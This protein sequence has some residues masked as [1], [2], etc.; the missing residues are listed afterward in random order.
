MV[1]QMR[2][3]PGVA[4]V[5]SASN[6]PA[7]GSLLSIHLA[8]WSSSD[9]RDS[10]DARDA[11]DSRS[12][13]GV[14]PTR[15]NVVDTAFFGAIAVSAL[16][17][18]LFTSADERSRNR[19]VVLSRSL[20]DKLLAGQDPVGRLVTVGDAST[21]AARVVGIVPDIAYALETEDKPIGEAYVLATQ[22]SATLGRRV[23]VVRA[24]VDP[25]TV[26]KELDATMRS[27]FPASVVESASS[28][29]QLMLEQTATSR[30]L[31]KLLISAALLALALAC[32][33]AYG[34]ASFNA[35]QGI[36]EVG[37]RLALGSS[38]HRILWLFTRRALVSG[39]C[40]LAV[41]L[42]VLMYIAPLFPMSFGLSHGVPARSM[43]GS[44]GLMLG[45]IT[46][47]VIVAVWRM[48]TMK[49]VDALR[50]T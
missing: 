39:C 21:T 27:A 16:E 7:G 47:A 26:K 44:A 50:A 12:V 36:R 8:P 37:V 14:P 4:G 28:V 35:R 48:A 33:G 6:A 42:G 1:E 24:A 3:L 46:L 45:A 30:T 10:R 38:Q 32:I 20:A 22:F 2:S 43:A 18:R 15:L 40:G 41:G 29:R 11:R 9:A 34:V 49:P 23:L 5:A 13:D 25:M 31:F 19:V 17:G